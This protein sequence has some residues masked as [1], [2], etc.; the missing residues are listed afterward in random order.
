MK[1]VHITFDY[2]LFFGINAGTVENSII[3]PTEL[4]I[5]LM[6]YNYE[7]NYVFV[8]ILKIYPLFLLF[9]LLLKLIAKNTIM[10]LYTAKNLV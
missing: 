1:S 4:I 8:Y 5:E 3:K 2:E 10:L 6:N 7:I 9:L